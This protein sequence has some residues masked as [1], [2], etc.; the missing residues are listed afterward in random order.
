MESYND[1]LTLQEPS[2]TIATASSDSLR[3]VTPSH[4]V[5]DIEISSWSDALRGQK[6]FDQLIVTDLKYK[7]RIQK[8]Y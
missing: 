3:F 1:S 6:Y 8:Y 2:S 4:E 5:V 7:V